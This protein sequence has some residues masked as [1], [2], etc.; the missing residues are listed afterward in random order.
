[1]RW[2][3]K[4][5]EYTYEVVYKAGT[6]NTNADA[7]SRISDTMVVKTR[8]QHQI[9]NPTTSIL[10]YEEYQTA[11]HTNLNSEVDDVT[12]DLFEA[13]DEF[14]LAHC[15]SADIKLSQGIALEFRRRYGHLQ[16]LKL[17]R[18]KK[19]DVIYYKVSTRYI[20]HLV[21]K[22]KHWQKPSYKDM[23][24]T[25]I[26]LRLVYVPNIGCGHDELDWTEVRKMI[27]YVF[28][29]SGISIRIYSK[30][31]LSEA[32]KLQIIIEHHSG[33]L[34][35]HR[36]VQQTIK[37]IRKQF[38]WDTMRR[39]VEDY[40]KKCASCQV[41][42]VD[43]RSTKQ[44]MVISTTASE[45]F[46]RTFIDVVGPLPQTFNGNVYILTIQ[47][48]LTKFS[49]AIPMANKEANTV[50]YHFVT[51]FVCTHGL[52]Q[53][54]ISEQGTEFLSKI[55]TETCK[56]LVVKRTTTSP[57]HPQANG[58]LERSHRTLAE[59]LRHYVDTD[60][61]NWDTYIP[62]AMFAYNSSVHRST[63]KQPYELLYGRTLRV[64]TSIA[65]PLEPRYNYEDY[66]AELRSKLQQAHQIARERL[67]QNKHRTK[68]KYDSF[69]KPITI[70]IGDKVL[71]QNRT[72]Q[73]KLS[74]KWLGPY[75]VIGLNANENV[76]IL[77]GKRKAK[78]HTNLLKLFGE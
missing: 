29:E 1:M 5:A 59:Y 53:N 45:P 72:R 22:E 68:D 28:H 6:T 16:E 56:L 71:L 51:S 69:A 42:K 20:L 60:Q 41:N 57:Y 52:P 11:S 73:G 47:C 40:I 36:G 23:Y 14:H 70:H 64:P 62:Y 15:I 75:P 54:L 32:D 18:P 9:T 43:N 58:A 65:K 24:D 31:D 49:V 55:F 13:S 66:H 37:R 12:G 76:T 27:Q 74:S 17:Q 77:K 4:L 39:D 2:R 67:I 61:Q 3:L 34:G 44:P 48:D 50:A 19:I 8:T 26:K 63:G 78:V 33:I 30:H 10:P 38:Q 21:T 25:L 7:L 35:G 46:E